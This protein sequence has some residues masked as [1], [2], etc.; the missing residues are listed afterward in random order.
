MFFNDTDKNSNTLS[1]SFPQKIKN[2]SCTIELEA[3]HEPFFYDL[4]QYRMSKTTPYSPE[5]VMAPVWATTNNSSRPHISNNQL[6]NHF[7]WNIA[8]PGRIIRIT[9][10]FIAMQC[11]PY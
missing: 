1:H 6:Q 7:T 2:S 9:G 4:I 8:W 11:G 3:E 5:Q 10:M